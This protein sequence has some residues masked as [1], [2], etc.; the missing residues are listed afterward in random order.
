M[1][2]LLQT[3]WLANYDADYVDYGKRQLHEYYEKYDD[4]SRPGDVTSGAAS[5]GIK[6]LP[7]NFDETYLKMRENVHEA[8]SAIKNVTGVNLP[9]YFVDLD[10]DS[11]AERAAVLEQFPENRGWETRFFGGGE[12]REKPKRISPL[13]PGLFVHRVASSV[14]AER[15]HSLDLV[16][17]DGDHTL[18]GVLSDL[19]NYAPLTKF[20][21]AGHD[22]NV[23]GYEEVC[24]AVMRYRVMEDLVPPSARLLQ[25]NDILQEDIVLLKEERGGDEDQPGRSDVAGGRGGRD[26]VE[27]RDLAGPIFLDSDYFWWIKAKQ[28]EEGWRPLGRENWSETQ[29]GTEWGWRQG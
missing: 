16:F 23:Y 12:N 7:T 2:H 22:W 11:D 29:W 28:R 13:Q 9:V 19:R 27:G 10:K 15:L 6:S 8:V 5:P 17:L 3:R 1:G 14:A 24:A 25:E 20:V 18:Y 4:A 26:V 21:I